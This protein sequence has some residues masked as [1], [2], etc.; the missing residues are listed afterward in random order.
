MIAQRS[1]I[2]IQWLLLL[3]NLEDFFYVPENCFNTNVVF[4]CK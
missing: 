1:H 2:I 3:T 4:P